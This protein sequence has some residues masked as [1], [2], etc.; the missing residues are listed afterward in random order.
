MRPGN[1]PLAKIFQPYGFGSEGGS[2]SRPI[3]FL[4]I[5]FFVEQIHGPLYVD[6]PKVPSSCH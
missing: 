6:W 3:Y 5:Y 1:W 4:T 2:S